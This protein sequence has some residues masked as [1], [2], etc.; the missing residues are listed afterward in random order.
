MPDRIA[1]SLKNSVLDF[2]AAILPVG[3]PPCPASFAAAH[4]SVR[5]PKPA[6]RPENRAS[7]LLAFRLFRHLVQPDAA[8]RNICSPK[9]GEDEVPAVSGRQPN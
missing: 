5:S 3:T 9:A 8:V 1:D 2:F 6:V 7:G 4:V